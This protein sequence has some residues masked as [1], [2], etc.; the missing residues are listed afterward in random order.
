MSR[1]F[2]ILITF[3]LFSL[4]FIAYFHKSNDLALD[5]GDQLATGKIILATHQVPKINLFSYTNTQFPYVDMQWFSEVIFYLIFSHFGINGLII[6]TTIVILLSFGLLYGYAFKKVPFTLLVIVSFLYIRILVERMY[7]RPEIFSYLFLSVFIFILFRFREKYTRLLYLLIPLELLWVNMHIY[8]IIGIFV[9]GCFYIE[10]LYKGFKTKNTQQAISLSVVFFSSLLVCLGNP[11]TVKGAFYP[12]T[13]SS[14]Y[15]FNVQ[16]NASVFTIIMK[17]PTSVP[18]SIL[19]FLFTSVTLLLL[20]LLKKK[21]IRLVDWLLVVPLIILSYNSIRNFPLFVFG[22]FTSYL[23]VCS[24]IITTLTSEYQKKYNVTKEKINFFISFVLIAFFIWQISIFFQNV[25]FGLG[26][27]NSNASLITFLRENNIKG[28]IFNNYDIGFTILY[29]LYPREK[30]F[31]NQKPEAYPATFFT[32]I[33]YP[34]LVNQSLFNAMAKKYHFNSIIFTITD[35]DSLP[36]LNRI[37]NDADW[38]LIYLD[39]YAVVFVKNTATNKKFSVITQ[40]EYKISDNVSLR[41]LDNLGYFLSVIGWKEKAL[42]AYEREYAQNQTNCPALHN[43]LYLMDQNN[44]LSVQYTDD[45]LAH[46]QQ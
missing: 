25:N 36:F 21:N 15:A 30:V 17:D 26:S 24:N 35:N 40:T 29:A 1:F 28:P 8:F 44:P 23:Y 33:Y 31:V 38:K 32:S 18:H 13:F 27:T 19:Y 22:T 2:K 3:L 14:N 37:V 42:A 7:V 46:C 43:I 6:L 20:L 4:I 12:F 11:N 39:P 9:I 5:L 41:D 10:A 16:E 45:Y 34:M